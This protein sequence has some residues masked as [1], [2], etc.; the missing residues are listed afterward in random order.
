[1]F[2]YETVGVPVVKSIDGVHF[3]VRQDQLTEVLVGTKCDADE[4][5][6]MG[7]DKNKL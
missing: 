5:V 7:G 6:D 3:Q 2:K 1:M 4:A